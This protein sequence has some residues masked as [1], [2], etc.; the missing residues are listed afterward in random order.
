[1]FEKLRQSLRDAMS[2]ASSPAEGRAVLAM[3][4]E[5]IVEAKVGVSQ[6][7]DAREL[8]RAQLERERTELD[9]VRRRGQLAATIHDEETVR[10]AARYEQRHAERVAVLE[11]KLVSQGDELALA[12]REVEE[13]TA[14]LRAMASGGVPP[15]GAMPA[16][17]PAEGADAGAGA[18]GDA[19]RPS[20]DALRREVE[21]A[22]RESL[23][24]RQLEE[25][26]RRMGR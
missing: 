11:R 24:S 13:M 6:I 26:K 23:A 17:A 22:A 9:T 2:R 10:V 18:E 1:M 14:Q 25:L 20:D 4:R 5:A 15:G 3:M 21:R 19:E 7:R 12:E 16:G 8:T